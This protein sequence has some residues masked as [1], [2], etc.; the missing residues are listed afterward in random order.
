M[1]QA[2]IYLFVSPSGRAYAGRRYCDHANFPRRGTGPLPDGYT[3][4][5]KLWQNVVRKHGPNLRWIILCRF[6]GSTP[7]VTLDAAER[8][9]IRLVRRLWAD[10]CA[11]IRAG[12]QGFTSAEAVAHW[13]DPQVQARRNATI[14]RPEVQAK[15]SANNTAAQNRPDV[16]AKVSAG[17]RESH[18]RPDVK[19]RRI[20]AN[21]VAQNRPD[22]RARKS[23]SMKEFT[24]SPEWRAQIA[25][26]LKGQPK[27]DEARRRMSIAAKRRCARD[28]ARRALAPFIQPPA[29]TRQG[30]AVWAYRPPLRLSLSVF[31]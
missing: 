19:A 8:R 3:G 17:L 15:I 9:A 7:R 23:A 24:K 5:G 6:P 2:V 26:R 20:A 28:K 16:K 30:A 27:S 12:G 10:R 18:A 11:N 25:A 1:Q 14:A 4:S 29:W 22:V 21:L 31:R 13:S